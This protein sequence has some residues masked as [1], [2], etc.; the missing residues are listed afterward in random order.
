MEMEPICEKAR[1]QMIL[2]A[3]AR[4]LGLRKAVCRPIPSLFDNF[5]SILRL[6]IVCM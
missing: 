3:A 4:D 2:T 5:L 1:G 6:T